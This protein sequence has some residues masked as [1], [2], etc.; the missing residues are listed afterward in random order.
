[1]S[2]ATGQHTLSFLLTN[3][4]N[5]TCSLFGYPKIE[6]LADKH[7]VLPY[8]IWHRGD[9]MVT[10]RP[11]ALVRV[12]QGHAAYV[13]I[14]QYR[15]DL[16]TRRPGSRGVAY[17]RIALASRDHQKLTLR[18][19]SSMSMAYCGWGN[20]RTFLAVSPFEPTLRATTGH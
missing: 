4:G 12:R 7:A 10:G 13:S 9:Q 18:A 20:P 11:P 2:E 15:C 5:A 16:G 3:L 19:P 8:V 17:I 6:M 1:L 14:N